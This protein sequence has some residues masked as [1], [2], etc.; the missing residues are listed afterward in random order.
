M[1]KLFGLFLIVA[2]SCSSVFAT[3]VVTRDDC[4][5]NQN[6]DMDTQECVNKVSGVGEDV[7]N[8]GACKSFNVQRYKGDS[9][10]KP[11]NVVTE[12]PKTYDK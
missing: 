5:L 9:D 12:S 10:L 11:F 4:T 2:L 1:K 8:N 7:A 6:F 3:I